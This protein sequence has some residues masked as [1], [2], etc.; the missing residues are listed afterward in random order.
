MT[1][2]D[3]INAGVML[4]GHRVYVGVWNAKTEEIETVWDMK[5]LSS[6]HPAL[7]VYPVQFIHPDE[8]VAAQLIIEVEKVEGL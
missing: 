4:Q 8:D 6:A 3:L 7:S 2:N 5:N 1:I